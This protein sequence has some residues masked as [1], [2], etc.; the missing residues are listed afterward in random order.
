MGR[1]LSNDQRSGGPV[2]ARGCCAERRPRRAAQG[3]KLPLHYAAAKGASL[4][5]MSLLLQS[6][7][8]KPKSKQP[9]KQRLQV[10]AL[11]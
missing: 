4:E 5:V 3:G 1:H 7:L 2:A 10:E 6:N 11:K 9:L 8:P